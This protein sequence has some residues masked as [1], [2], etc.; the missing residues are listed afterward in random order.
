MT[1]TGTLA[2]CRHVP[3]WE[4]AFLT[5]LESG[6]PERTAMSSAGIGKANVA[7]RA[8]KDEVFKERYEAA[9]AVGSTRK[10]G[11]IFG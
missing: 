10:A 2:G 8:A 1:M 9:K 3:G 5:A 4:R 11:S 7:N 6:Y